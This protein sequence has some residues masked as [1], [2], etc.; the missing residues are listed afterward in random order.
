MDKGQIGE[1]LTIMESEAKK[2]GAAVFEVEKAKN[3]P[4]R[5]LIFTMLSARTKDAT[6]LPIAGGLFKIANNPKSMLRIPRKKLEKM[7][8]GIGFYRVKAKNLHGLCRMLLDDFHG[9]VPETLEELV[10]LPGV[11]RKTA[12][13]VLNIAFGQA[14]IGVDT[15]VHRISNRLS[16]VRTKTPEKTEQALQNVVPA[17][18]IKQF[19]KVLVAYGQTICT[20]ISPWCSICRIHDMCPRAGV[21]KSR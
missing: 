4:F 18:H 3:T 13:I 1:A 20:P 15:H 6:L 14:T 11:G 19:N 16:L 8:Y 21:T 12:N 10:K 7:L 2:I 5:T 17:R 9:K